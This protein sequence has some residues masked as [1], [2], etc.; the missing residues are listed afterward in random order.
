MLASPIIAGTNGEEAV[1]S[2]YS[3]YIDSLG[4]QS[5][6]ADD[7]VGDNVSLSMDKL[8]I[9]TPGA[10]SQS[11]RLGDAMQVPSAY[12]LDPSLGSADIQIGRH[13]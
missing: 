11:P 12:D 4:T 13:G 9:S 5:I 10:T 8:H 6:S 3:N 1:E 2:D 7:L